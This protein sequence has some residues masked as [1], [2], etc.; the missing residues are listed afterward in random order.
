MSQNIERTLAQTDVAFGLR[1]LDS[2]LLQADFVGTAGQIVEDTKVP[3]PIRELFAAGVVY[4]REGLRKAKE[5][6]ANPFDVAIHASGSFHTRRGTFL[7]PT[8]AIQPIPGQLF[9]I[10][11]VEDTLRSGDSYYPVVGDPRVGTRQTPL[12]IG[13]ALVGEKTSE[14]IAVG[15]LPNGTLLRGPQLTTR[16]TSPYPPTQRVFA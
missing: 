1:R 9:A 10:I 16:R 13:T 11:G 8:Q 15:I 5:G 2:G 14:T 7:Y 4:H 6:A 3:P 12:Y